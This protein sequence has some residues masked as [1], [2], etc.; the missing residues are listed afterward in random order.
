MVIM[1]FHRSGMKRTA[2]KVTVFCW[3]GQGS[4]HGGDGIENIKLEYC[5]V[6]LEI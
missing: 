1:E 5:N 6:Y 3:G 4:L 2:E